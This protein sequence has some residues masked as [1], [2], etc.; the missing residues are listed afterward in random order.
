MNSSASPDGSVSANSPRRS[1]ASA[2]PN[3]SSVQILSTAKARPASGREGLAQQVAQSDAPALP[4]RRAPREGV[5]LLA[6]PLRPHHVVE[7]Q[8]RR[9]AWGEPVELET[10]PV[11]DDLAEP[12]DLGMD[13][14]LRGLV[15]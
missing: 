14:D 15:A 5:M 3:R 8:R 4:G 13:T 9:V 11:H 1:R 6:S 12:A 7:Q 10:G 2:G